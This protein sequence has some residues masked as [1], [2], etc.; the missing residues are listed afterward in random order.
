MQHLVFQQY[1]TFGTTKHILVFG[2]QKLADVWPTCNYNSFNRAITEKKAAKKTKN[3][4]N[5]SGRKT[6]IE[7]W[8]N[9]RKVINKITQ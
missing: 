6:N 5:K 1:Y 3:K 2:M 4:T 7:I 9:Y 8:L